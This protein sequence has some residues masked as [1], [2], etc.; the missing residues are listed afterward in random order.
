M[1]HYKENTGLLQHR[2]VANYLLEL[3]TLQAGGL[4]HREVAS[5]LRVT[6]GD[7]KLLF[8]RIKK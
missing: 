4:Q 6:S 1:H 3:K 8:A 5:Y 2:E 7:G